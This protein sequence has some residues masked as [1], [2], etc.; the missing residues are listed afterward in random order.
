MGRCL[1]SGSAKDQRSHCCS[2]VRWQD[3]P[4]VERQF[5]KL[6]TVQDSAQR[7][8]DDD[9]LSGAIPLSSVTLVKWMVNW[10]HSLI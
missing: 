9:A 4:N 10:R 8:G 1:R 3:N 5:I 7:S 6:L 2:Q